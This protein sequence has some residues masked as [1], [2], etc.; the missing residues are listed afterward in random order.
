MNVSKLEFRTTPKKELLV[1]ALENKLFIEGWGMQ[2]AIRYA[3]CDPKFFRRCYIAIAFIY[4]VPVAVMI[5]SPL[6]QDNWVMCYVKPQFRRLR[7]GTRLFR[8]MCKKYRRRKDDMIFG[9]GKRGSRKFFHSIKLR[10]EE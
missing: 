4:T 7:I 6:C 5:W 2:Q 10:R 9:V 1:T 8:H 3:L